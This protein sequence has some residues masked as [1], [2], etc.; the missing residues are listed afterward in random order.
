[1]LIGI[2]AAIALGA[3][4]PAITVFMGRLTDTFVDFEL[5]S[6]ISKLSS[7]INSQNNNNNNSNYYENQLKPL[8]ASEPDKYLSKLFTDFPQLKLNVIQKRFKLDNKS[9]VDKFD[10]TVFHGNRQFVDDFEDGANRWS[11]LIF[12]FAVIILVAGYVI[13]ATFSAA[14][15]HQKHRI[16]ILFFKAVLRQDITWYDTKTTGDFATKVTADLDKLQEGIGDKVALCIFSFSTVLCSLGTAFYYGW[17]LTLVILSLTPVLV[18]LFI[19]IGII[20]ARYATTE[21]ESYSKAGTV[22]EEVLG[23]IRT[24]Y[25]FGGQTKDIKR[26][27]RNLEPAKK[28]GIKRQVYIGCGLGVMWFVIYLSFGL[29]FWYGIRLI[30]RSIDNNDS[31]YVASN[32]TIVFFSVLIGTFSIGQTVPYFE[33]FAQARGS[34]ALIFEVMNRVPEIDSSSQSGDK[35]DDFKGQVELRN[36]HF[37]YPARSGVQV[38][39]G[40]SLVAEPG[41]TVALVGPSGCGKSTVIQ[42]IQRFYDVKDG[43]VLIG[44]RNIKDLNVGWLRDQIGL[45]GQEPALFG[46]SIAENIKLGYSSANNNDIESAAKDANAYDFIMRLPKQFNTLVGERGSQLSGGQKQRIAIA[47]ALVRKPKI[48]LLDESTSA[49]D[50]QSESIVQAAL[51]RASVGRTTFIVAHRLTT[52]RQANKIIVINRDI[53]EEIGT[54]EELMKKEGLY[55]KLV[56]SQ[57]RTDG[58]NNNSEKNKSKDLDKEVTKQ[59]ETTTSDIE[60]NKKM[61]KEL[62]LRKK[63]SGVSPLILPDPWL[64]FYMRLFKLLKPDKYLVLTGLLMAFLMGLSVPAFAIVF[65]E[66]LAT[67]SLTS[68]DKMKEKSLFYA[69]LFVGI[70]IMTGC[71]SALQIYAFGVSGERL[72]MKLRLQVFTAMLNQEI[73]W[74]DRQ[75]NSTGAL[76]SRLSSDT[77]SV[78]GAGGSRLSTLV[79][80]VSTLGIGV[81]IA[82]YYSWKLGL[83]TMCFIPLVIASTYFQIKIT[84]D[85]LVKDKEAQEESSKIAIEAIGSIRTVASLH[86]ETT[87]INKYQKSLQPP[88][89]KS[90]IQ[91]HLRGITYGLAI[92]MSNFAYA[93][94]LFYG[95]KLIINNELSYGNL[96]KSTEALILG[97]SI[98][99]QAVAFAPNFQKGKLAAVYIFKL[100][101]RIP[102]IIVDPLKG[103][104]PLS[105]EGNVDIK[106]VEFTYTT[107]SDQKILNGLSFDVLKG[108]RVALVGSSGCGKSTIIQLIQRFYDTDAGHVILDNKNIVDLNI[109]WLRSKLGIVSQEPVLFGYSIAENIA[110]GDNSRVVPMDEIV[111]AAEKANIHNFIKSLPMGYETPVG[112]KG[113][114]LSGGQ[115]QRIAIARA[116]IRDPQ[117]LLLDEATSALDSES[118]KVVQ[119]ALNEAQEGRTCIVIAHRL[120]TIEN[121]DKIVVVD[122]GKAVEEGTHQQL[123][124]KKGAYY[125]LYNIQALANK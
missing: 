103:D 69:L 42:L 95:S 111:R 60:I 19:I 24:V 5:F 113:T 96:F 84:S 93:I 14:A 35:I 114:Q 91:A 92:S 18:I 120:S 117:I 102:K 65:G 36:V 39:R 73:G 32:M 122:K 11:L 109:S 112:D 67:L 2:V 55:Y 115:K 29:G 53:V 87:F 40:L 119:Q 82:M 79:Q 71:A 33:A 23:G 27:D 124:D 72:T 34:A 64:R 81:V 52:I 97:T 90:K 43:E 1:M 44:S 30:I 104:K 74:F 28:S 80:A 38:L 88:Y 106:K 57:Q 116:L 13:V 86:Q 3:G 59:L 50:N 46:C 108:Q 12:V 41:E 9:F 45:V 58:E 21:A 77:S 76:C 47:R 22:V 17:E 66:I 70:G 16:R 62:S 68:T 123:L 85:Q 78:Q 25:A 56:K 105:C 61:D 125:G 7:V 94:A 8:K 99:G 20:Q 100:L 118:E 63:S 98:I 89:N 49:L 110:Y 107:R 101:D 54:H 51:D 121:A 26:Y 37:G 4:Q 10:K 6:K 75:E 48:L 83:V 31:L 15:N